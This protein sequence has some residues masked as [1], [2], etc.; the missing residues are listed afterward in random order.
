[1]GEEVKIEFASDLNRHERAVN[2]VRFSP[3]GAHLAS[4][5][6][7]KDYSA[8]RIKRLNF[9]LMCSVGQVIIWRQKEAGEEQA[10]LF[11]DA[12]DEGVESWTALKVLR[13]HLE[14]V[15]SLAW[16]PD[17]N[18]LL[19]GS[20]D[21]T[22]MIWNAVEAKKL[23]VFKDHKGFVQGVAW[24]PKDRFLATICTDR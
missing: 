15:Y 23:G 3:N 9:Y 18:C 17:S 6:D 14:D 1:V 24:C 10:N 16:S 21:N 19:S 13:G 20:V 22:V 8:Y 7:G 2:I 5:D 4:G 11:D 12:T